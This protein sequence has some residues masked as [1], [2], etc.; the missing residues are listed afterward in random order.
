[1]CASQFNACTV[2]SGIKDRRVLDPPPVL[3]L[4]LFNVNSPYPPLNSGNT[5]DGDDR[6][7]DQETE[8]DYLQVPPL[9]SFHHKL[10]LLL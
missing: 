8:V 7:S 9:L 3:E 2:R 10:L 6:S 4:K 1:M 5:P